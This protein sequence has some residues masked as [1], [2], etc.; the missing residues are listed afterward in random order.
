MKLPIGKVAEEIGVTI[1]TLCR[2]E[3][4]GKVMKVA[5]V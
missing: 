3:R 1:D 5:L 4:E 2:W